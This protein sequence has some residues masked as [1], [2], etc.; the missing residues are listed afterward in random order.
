IELEVSNVLGA[1]G[2]VDVRFAKRQLNTSVIVQDGQASPLWIISHV[3]ALKRRPN[4]CFALKPRK[5]SQAKQDYLVFH[6]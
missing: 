1:N 4:Q 6:K 2:A 3:R 5:K